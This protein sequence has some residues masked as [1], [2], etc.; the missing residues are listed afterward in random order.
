MANSYHN[1]QNKITNKR[2]H[3][4]SYMY[5]RKTRASPVCNSHQFVFVIL[6]SL[7]NALYLE[8]RQRLHPLTFS[9]R[10]TLQR[11]P[12]LASDR[13]R[14]LLLRRRPAV[15]AYCNNAHV[16]RELYER[17]VASVGLSR[18]VFAFRA[19]IS[20]SSPPLR[21][22]YPPYLNPAE[23]PLRDRGSPRKARARYCARR[24][25]KAVCRRGCYS[26][27]VFSRAAVIKEAAH[28]RV[29]RGAIA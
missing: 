19:S 27:K 6:Y 29:S 17:V 8:Q 12:Q 4:S 24:T 18:K 3:E 15:V 16:P 14:M 20:Y 22:P 5:Y 25:I 21:I 11:K 13:F 10:T 7:N 1:S 26:I 28:E 9:R 2:L 23:S